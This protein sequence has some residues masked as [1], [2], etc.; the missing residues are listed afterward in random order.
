M[1]RSW[2]QNG[3]ASWIGLVVSQLSIALT[4]FVGENVIRST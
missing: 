3:D 1:L 4:M 2:W